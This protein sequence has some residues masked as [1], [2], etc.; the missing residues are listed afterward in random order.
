MKIIDFFVAVGAAFSPLK[1]NS[2]AGK[3]EFIH[4][5]SVEIFFYFILLEF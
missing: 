3:N 4:P 1:L 2:E 5:R